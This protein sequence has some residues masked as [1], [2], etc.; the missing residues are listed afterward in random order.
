MLFNDLRKPWYKPWVKSGQTNSNSVKVVLTKVL[1]YCCVYKWVQLKREQLFLQ[2]CFIEGFVFFFLFVS[3]SD[4]H[5]TSLMTGLSCIICLQKG[6]MFDKNRE[7]KVF[8][9]NTFTSQ[10]R[11]RT[12]FIV[13]FKHF[14]RTSKIKSW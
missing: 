1:L 10:L 2:Y 6:P 12:V 4:T 13:K 9:R 11:V 3:C 8:S 14:L 7:K 5:D